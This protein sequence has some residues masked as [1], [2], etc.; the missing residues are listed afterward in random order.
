MFEKC[1]N[2]IDSKNG[3]LLL[4]ASLAAKF[5]LVFVLT[6]ETLFRRGFVFKRTE[7]VKVLLK[8]VLEIG[9]FLF[10]DR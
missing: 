4:S 8:T 3:W 7:R 6:K 1:K 2:Q 10:D 5:G 9:M